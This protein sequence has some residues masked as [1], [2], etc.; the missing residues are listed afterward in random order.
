MANV[1]AAKAA[2]EKAKL[3]LSYARI[4]APVAGV[5]TQRN[6][7]P[8]ARILAGEQLL[9]IVQT[10]NLW[11]T[12]N[13]KETQLERMHPGQRVKVHVDAMHQDFKGTVESM[14]AI[15]GSRTSVLPP[16]NATG[17]ACL[18]GFA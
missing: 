4:V 15:T 17:S 18:C 2:L 1:E 16:E 3:N 10:D 8:G 11:V 9:M 5:V 6:A 7:E 14:P 12:A 13:F